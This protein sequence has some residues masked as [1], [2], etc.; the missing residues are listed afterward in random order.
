ML[1]ALDGFSNDAFTQYQAFLFVE[2]IQDVE[3]IEL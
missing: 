3:S 1:G 2:I